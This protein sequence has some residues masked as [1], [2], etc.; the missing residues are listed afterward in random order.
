[1]ADENGWPE[2][3][4][5]TTAGDIDASLPR[6][7]VRAAASVPQGRPANRRAARAAMAPTSKRSFLPRRAKRSSRSRK[8]Y[9]IGRSFAV[10]SIVAALVASVAIPAYAA[11]Q[12]TALR[13]IQQVAA[14]DAQSI[15]V[16]SDTAVDTLDRDSY[17]ATTAD[18]IAKKKAEDAAAA[19]ARDE[20]SSIASIRS[21]I[22]LDMHA[23]G[24]GAI[25]WPLAHVA[26][27]GDGFGSR[28]GE[29][30]GVDLLDPALTP[31]FAAMAGVVRVSQESYGGYGVGIS[32]DSVVNGQKV[33]TLY[34]HMTRGSRQVQPGQTVEAGQL[35]GLVGSTGRST[36]NHLHFEVA[37]NGARVDPLAWLVT[38]VGPVP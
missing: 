21:R 14:D 35:I 24:T 19:R 31:I 27:V 29:H 32:I 3:D 36:A 28:G 4:P 12:S 22:D 5:E 1:M 17:S 11:T 30:Q 37:I 33:S 7:G 16:A 2:I 34:G 15:I 20:T 25:R 23:P 8:K 13:T 18:E 10:Y 26:H 6:T 9:R 38:N